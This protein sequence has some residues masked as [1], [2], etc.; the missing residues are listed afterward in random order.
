VRDDLLQYYERELTFLRQMGKEFA[1]KYPKV[2]SRL[3]L[4]PN[5]CEDPH[6]ERML[7]AFAFLAA[8]VHLKIDDQFPEV[9]EAVLNIVHP[10][11]VRPLPSM[12]LVEF[13]LDPDQGKLS[14]GYPVPRGTPLYTTRSAGPVTCKFRSCY[15]TVLWPLGVSEAQWLPTDRLRPPVR[16]PEA[17]GALRLELQCFPDVTFAT[18]DLSTLRFFLD[19]ESNLVCTLYELLCNSCTRILVRDPERP[20]R[21]PVELPPDAVRP[22]GFADEEAVLPYPRRSLPAYRL[23]QEYFAF[24]EKYLFLDLSGFDQVR[25][26]GPGRKAEIIFLIAP[27]EHGHRRQMLEMGVSPRTFRLG[28]TPIINLF[29][30][31]AEPVPLDQRKAE[32]IVDPD[33]RQRAATEVYSVDRVVA[34]TAGTS[35]Q[36]QIEP[37][38]AYRHD[39]THARQQVFWNASRRPSGWRSD[40]RM[41]VFLSFVDRSGRVVHPDLDVATPYLTCFNAD[42]PNRLAFG[43]EAGDFDLPKGSGPIGS[44]VALAKPTPVVQPPLGKPLLWRLIS[45]LSL[46][47]LSL[48]GGEPDALREML[49]L[50]NFADTVAGNKQIQGILR[51]QGRPAY[52]RVSSEVGISFARGVRVDLEL[53][54]EEFT[55]GGAYLFA[56]VLDRFL[57]MYASMNSFSILAVRT[58]QRKGLLREWAPRAG[59]RTLL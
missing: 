21:P 47:Y 16:A 6:V 14:G 27:F 39:T 5:K 22:V 53:D 15:D 46:N 25:A 52:A 38:Y 55:G 20:T 12:S 36:W 49:R 28:C 35:E 44:V 19:G 17:A 32:Y 8:R 29:D 13:R 59:W 18:L 1:D 34:L 45:Q 37:L 48:V 10:H 42:I 26:A 51:V 30:K 2:A 11:Y 57:G 50:H 4:E 43:N 54:E 56:S 41:D 58:R 24:P 7:E 3:Q 40:G 31:T 9:S 33:A 23:L